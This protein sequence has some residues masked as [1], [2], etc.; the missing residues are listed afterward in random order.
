M[1]GT[2]LQWGFF[3]HLGTP[4]GPQMVELSLVNSTSVNVSWL[5]PENDGNVEIIS[6]TV[7]S[8]I[9]MSYNVRYKINLCR[10]LESRLLTLFLVR[11]S[12]LTIRLQ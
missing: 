5:P 8:T 7:S 12:R 2:Y 10:F 1:H 9:L 4:S 11:E 6:Y 3:S